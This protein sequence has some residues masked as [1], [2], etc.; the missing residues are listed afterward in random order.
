MKKKKKLICKLKLTDIINHYNYIIRIRIVL[1][2]SYHDT[3]NAVFHA[4]G[5]FSVSLRVGA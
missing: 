1:L 4:A 2:S 5:V 3:K